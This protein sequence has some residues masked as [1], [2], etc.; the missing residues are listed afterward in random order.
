MSITVVGKI[1]TAHAGRDYVIA[2]SS[3]AL[4]N[5]SN[6]ILVDSAPLSDVHMEI[7]QNNG[8]Y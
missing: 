3:G 2:E 8:S 5:L 7:Y 6:N 4:Q 1:V